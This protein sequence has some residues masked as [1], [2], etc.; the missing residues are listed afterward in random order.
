MIFGRGIERESSKRWEM[1]VL[2][3]RIFLEQIRESN[4]S[5]IRER[6]HAFGG[7]VTEASCGVWWIS[8]TTLAN[9]DDFLRLPRGGSR[10]GGPFI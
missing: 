7:N 6:M 1:D 9:G 2:T 10:G 5:C 8:G 4:V 3:Y